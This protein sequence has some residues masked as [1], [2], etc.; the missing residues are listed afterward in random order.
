MVGVEIVAD[1]ATRRPFPRSEKK[2]ESVTARAFANGLVIY[3]G[4]GC[5]D[6]RAGDLVVL[7][8]PFVTTEAEI[9]EMTSIL[10]RTLVELSL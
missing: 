10:E 3:P 7:A 6:G 1:K 4:T 9:A 8:P 5:A 2:A